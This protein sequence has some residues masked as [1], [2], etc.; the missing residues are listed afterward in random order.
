MATHS[1]GKFRFP[2]FFVLFFGGVAFSRNMLT[3]LSSC[4]VTRA[5]CESERSPLV[6]R[7]IH[8]KNHIKTSKLANWQIV[9][10]EQQN[11]TLEKQK[12]EE[13]QLRRESESH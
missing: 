5:C 8:I 11:L 9:I 7:E 3:K 2:L 12:R 4:K 6:P 13:Q 10:K 1:T